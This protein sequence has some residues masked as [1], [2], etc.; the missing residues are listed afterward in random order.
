M[1]GWPVD[2]TSNKPCSN[3]DDWKEVNPDAPANDDA[4]ESHDVRQRLLQGL[5]QAGAPLGVRAVRQ[6]NEEVD[7]PE[8]G[9]PVRPQD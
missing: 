6:L 7:G 1:R 5:R 8:S 2:L 9:R 3:C 4:A